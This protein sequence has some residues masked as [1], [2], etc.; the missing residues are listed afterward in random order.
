MDLKN[1]I[2]EIETRT[3]PVLTNKVIEH[4][5]ILVLLFLV[6]FALGEFQPLAHKYFSRPP[7]KPKAGKAPR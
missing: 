6:G 3:K 2:R 7:A 1:E 4:L 5:L